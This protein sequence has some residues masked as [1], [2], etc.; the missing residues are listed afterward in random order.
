[1]RKKT[2]LI[3]GGADIDKNVGAMSPPIYQASTFKQNGVGNFTYE[4]AR[5]GNPTRD[6]VETLIADL[7][8]GKRGFA[9]ASGM[10]AIAAVMDLFQAGDHILLTDDVYGGTFR[11]M[12][13][14][15]NRRNID[16]DFVDS[17]DLDKVREG[18]REETKAIFIETPTNPLLKITDIKE[19]ANIAKEKNVLLIADNT[20]NT[21]YW[22]NPIDL[23]ANIVVHSATKYLG[24]HSDLVAGLVV[25]DDEKLG[26]EIHFIQNA[27]GGVLAPND[28]W[29]LVRGIRTLGIRME[30]I[31]SNTQKIVEYLVDH[32]KVG[33]VYYPG[34]PEHPNRD[35]HAKQSGG[36]GGMVSFTVESEEKAL[37]VL[38]KVR[39]FS[40]AESLGAVESLISLPA[41]MT[42]ASIPRERRL[43]LGIE[44]GL[45][46]ISVGLEDVEDLI[47]D[48]DQALQ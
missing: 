21:P 20:F 32:P 37:D 36:F 43:E 17:S 47:E 3:H 45:I 11:Y 15:L 29:L 22:Q 14:I 6:A 44:D 35:I 28:S 46:R 7:E 30:E 48:L 24:G 1:M 34:L 39:Y 27:S 10:A 16:V 26:E 42:H 12:T 23:G 5:T 25:V 41:K 8:K 18:I 4:Y 40:L 31:E 33:K 2:R 38:N 9:F 19:L 13:K